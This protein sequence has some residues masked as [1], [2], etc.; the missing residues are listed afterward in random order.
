MSND[1]VGNYV[2]EEEKGSL[3]VFPVLSSITLM[4]SAKWFFAAEHSSAVTV[5]YH[6]TSQQLGG[7]HFL[8]IT[9]Q[10]LPLVSGYSR[11]LLKLRCWKISE[12][13]IAYKF[14]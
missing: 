2:R 9:L 3:L 7:R 13:L 1:W 14:K 8:S 12:N 6:S 4:K 5:H 11:Q 10:P